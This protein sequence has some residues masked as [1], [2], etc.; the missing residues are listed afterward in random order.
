MCHAIARVLLLTNPI[1]FRFA[2][3]MQASA[4]L[5]E[6][7]RLLGTVKKAVLCLA[8]QL[9]CRQTGTTQVQPMTAG[10]THARVTKFVGHN[11]FELRSL[12]SPCM[13]VNVRAECEMSVQCMLAD[14]HA[15]PSPVRLAHGG[16]VCSDR[17]LLSV[18][19]LAL[20]TYSA[21]GVAYALFN[22]SIESCR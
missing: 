15:G 2:P 19:R 21:S 18:M 17:V 6:G 11:G 4:W 9:L 8:A 14:D 5:L 1:S 12:R 20:L 10:A 3:L 7:R 13:P 22:H 16:H